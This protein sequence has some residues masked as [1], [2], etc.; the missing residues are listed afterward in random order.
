MSRRYHINPKT[1][2]PS[3]CRA[4]KGNCPYGGKSGGENHFTTYSEAQKRS[5]E[6]FMESYQI[7]P[8]NNDD[9]IMKEIE[10]KKKGSSSKLENLPKGNNF[11]AYKAI[12][13]TDDENL[14]MGIIEG[15]VYDYKGWNHT[16]IALQN[17]NIP[18]D[19][20]NEA[21]FDYP[22]D[23]ENETR[24]WLVMNPSLNDK[25]LM[26]IIQ[27]QNEDMAVRALAFR[28]PNLSDKVT[29]HVINKF[30]DALKVLPYSM[31]L[32][33]GKPTPET[34][35]L[36]VRAMAMGGD[37]YKGIHAAQRL[38]MS[39]T[40]WHMKFRKEIEEESV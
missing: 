40:P 7:L 13:N 2:V 3:V 28:N 8:S 24:R 39:Y 4:D 17:P 34:D 11:E 20:L 5:Q 33:N 6:I 35:E 38:G 15:E 31:V 21:M 14:V 22:D 19:F 29:N 32:Y 10:S 9:E 30:P 25:Q 16:S 37:E 1:G 18:K 27:D 23:F 12:M 26:S 36:K